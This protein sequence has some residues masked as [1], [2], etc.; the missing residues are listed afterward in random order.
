[1]TKLKDIMWRIA[2]AHKIHE[3]YCEKTNS[4]HCAKKA[5]DLFAMYICSVEENTFY[6]YLRTEVPT[7]YVLKPWIVDG[8]NSMVLSNLK[9]PKRLSDDEMLEFLEECRGVETL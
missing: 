1:M 3:I 2:V 6:R 5:Y 4:A 8:F 7:E 9:Y